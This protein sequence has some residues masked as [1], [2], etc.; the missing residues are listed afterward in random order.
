MT[1][2]SVINLIFYPLS[3]YVVSRQCHFVACP[4]VLVGH[5]V[6]VLSLAICIVQFFFYRF[7]DLCVPN[8][9]V[10]CI[11]YRVSLVLFVGCDCLCFDVQFTFQNVSCTSE[12][13]YRHVIIDDKGRWQDVNVHCNVAIPN[14]DRQT[15]KGLH[16]TLGVRLTL[17]NEEMGIVFGI[18]KHLSR[19]SQFNDSK[20]CMMVSRFFRIEDDYEWRMAPESELLHSQDKGIVAIQIAYLKAGFRFPIHKF[21][22]NLFTYYFHFLLAQCRLTP[23]DKCH[24][25]SLV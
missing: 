10:A 14:S 18:Y 24:T 19:E 22:S 7:P 15:S 3:M 6:Y 11:I 5:V 9:C 4:R 20:Q 23:N 21:M 25:C 13:R 8:V 12:S 17:Q 2:T 1:F 16:P